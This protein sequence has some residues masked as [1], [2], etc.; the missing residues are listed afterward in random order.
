ME[1]L[2][3]R[4]DHQARSLGDLD[5]EMGRVIGDEPIGF[6]LNGGCQDRDIVPMAN[7]CPRVAVLLVRDMRDPLDFQ[8]L[9]QSSK[10][11]VKRAKTLVIAFQTEHNIPLGFFNDD[12][13]EDELKKCGAP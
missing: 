8:P 12:L 6:S 13:S 4:D 9:Q 3:W 2:S 11:V 1:E 7:E 10:V 5:I